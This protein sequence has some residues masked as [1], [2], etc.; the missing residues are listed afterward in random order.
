MAQSHKVLVVAVGALALGSAALL[1]GGC[2]GGERPTEVVL[3]THDSF[4]VS[5][6]VKR[7]F[8]EE[9]GLTLRILQ[10]G[11]AGE[12]VTKALLTAGNPEGDVLFGVDNNLLTRA[13]EGDVFTPYESPGLADVDETWV[14][15]PEHRVTPIDHGEVCLNYDKAWFAERGIAPPG[16]LDDLAEP[17]YEGLLVVENPATSTPG[18]AFL[19][20]TIA[21]YGDPGWQDYWRQLRANDVLVVDGW[22]EAYTVRFSGAAGSSGKRPIVVSYASSPPAEVIFRDPRPTEA[23]T[24]VVASSCF[25]QIEFAGILRGARNEEGAREL[26]DFMLSARFQEDIPLQMFV[27]PVNREAQLPPEFVEHA[28]VPDAPLE[29]SPEEIEAN[30]ERWVSEWTRIVVR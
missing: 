10:A 19:L 3:V 6:E 16:S 5:E 8:E 4:A 14:L 1:A 29:L 9:S 11:D 17:A 7:A 2:G 18:L 13:L 21:R 22:E 20:A 12:V 25:R 23:P 15:D 28:V 26:I 24:G 30:R 27:F